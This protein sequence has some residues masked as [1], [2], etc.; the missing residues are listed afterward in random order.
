MAFTF[1]EN[2]TERHNQKTELIFIHLQFVS[3]FS[4]HHKILP[5]SDKLVYKQCKLIARRKMN[6]SF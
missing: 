6:L 1:I 2:Y 3:Q 4:S 5:L